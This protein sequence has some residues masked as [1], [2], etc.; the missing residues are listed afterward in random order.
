MQFVKDGPSSHWLEASL[1]NLNAMKPKL[2]LTILVCAIQGDYQ[3]DG[4]WQRRISK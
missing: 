2:R 3:Q 1:V 4:P